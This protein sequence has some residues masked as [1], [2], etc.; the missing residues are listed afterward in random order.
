MSYCE[1]STNETAVIEI[2]AAIRGP[3]FHAGIVLL[4]DRVTETAPIV[5]YMK[6]W[7]RKRVRDYCNDRDWNISVVWEMRKCGPNN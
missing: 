2:L 1:A 7:S 3:N 4:N 6:G 5:K